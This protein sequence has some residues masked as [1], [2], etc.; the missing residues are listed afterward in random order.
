[1]TRMWPPPGPA[2]SA[3]G[4]PNQGPGHTGAGL[5]RVSFSSHFL[6]LSRFLK[7]RGSL[8]LALTPCGLSCFFFSR[9]KTK[10][11]QDRE[12]ERNTH[13]E[14]QYALLRELSPTMATR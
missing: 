1:M 7:G 11:K 14:H 10:Q 3:S 12:R 8:F 6:S 5:G 4:H 9:K 13:D 2:P